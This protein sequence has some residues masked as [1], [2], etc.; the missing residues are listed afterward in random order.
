MMPLI[1]PSRPALHAPLKIPAI[2]LNMTI[3]REYRIKK[4]RIFIFL[5][6]N[7]LRASLPGDIRAKR[8]ADYNFLEC[9]AGAK[10]ILGGGY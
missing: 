9:S 8:T 10:T 2:T 4:K 3:F 6:S 1:T 5:A 7:Q